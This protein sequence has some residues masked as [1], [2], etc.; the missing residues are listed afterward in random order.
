MGLGK[1][2][3]KAKVKGSKG[4]V[5]ML[6]VNAKARTR[7]LQQLRNPPILGL[8]SKSLKPSPQPTLPPSSLTLT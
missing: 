5:R 4:K 8:K 3:A 7:K 6:K 1:Q 2:N